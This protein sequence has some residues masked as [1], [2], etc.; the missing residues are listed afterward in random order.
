MAM[1]MRSQPGPPRPVSSA[2]HDQD[3]AIP[4]GQPCPQCDP[5]ELVVVDGEVGCS[6]CGFR[7]A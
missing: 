2:T 1:V 6:A 4:L 3:D 7:A 5:G